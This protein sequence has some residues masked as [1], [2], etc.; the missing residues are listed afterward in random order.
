MIRVMDNHITQHIWPIFRSPKFQLCLNF[1]YAGTVIRHL[2]YMER[3][4]CDND[5]KEDNLLDRRSIRYVH[6]NYIGMF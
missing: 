6:I 3:R 4:I 5:T 1:V 2:K